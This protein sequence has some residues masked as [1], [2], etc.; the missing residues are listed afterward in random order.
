MEMAEVVYGVSY[1]LLNLLWLRNITFGCDKS[2]SE[3]MFHFVHHEFIHVCD[4][5][6]STLPMETTCSARSK[7]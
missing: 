4:T 5:Y 1:S 6:F 2:I 3:F 7:S